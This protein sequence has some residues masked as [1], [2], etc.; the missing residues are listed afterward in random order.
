MLKGMIYNPPPQKKNPID[1]QKQT[2]FAQY[3]T[4]FY[5]QTN[6]KCVYLIMF[7]T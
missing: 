6:K 7:L 2:A 3:K 5:K 1:I 4:K